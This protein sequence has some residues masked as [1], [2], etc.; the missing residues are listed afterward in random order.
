MPLEARYFDGRHATSRLV[1]LTIADDRVIV[2]GEGVARDEP[3]GSVSIS[4]RIGRTPR[5]VRFV[6]DAYCEVLDQDA[7]DGLLAA[8]GLA[9]GSLTRWEQNSR[10]VAALLVGLVLLAAVAYRYGLPLMAEA[11][12]RRLP[13]SALNAV[14]R[15]ALAVFDR[16][17][18]VPSQLSED[19]QRALT[20][21]FNRAT[22][23][24]TSIPMSLQFRS[25]PSL[26]ANAMALPNGIVILTDDLEKL[27]ASDDEILAVLAHEAGHV[28]ARHGL[29]NV[30]QSS[31]ISVFVTWYLGDIN[32]IV[33]AAPAALLEAK[34]SR[35]LERDADRY[36][37]TFLQANGLQT[38]LLADILQKLEASR[39][40]GGFSGATA[41][42]SSHPTTDERIR[43]L[44]EQP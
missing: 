14:S 8:A 27:A 15:Q 40:G 18:F 6:D 41:Y 36:A 23:P 32:A 22:H 11:S 9:Q 24:E 44:R 17:L 1:T 33:A 4:E 5:F 35:D 7:L 38:S 31:V 3:L 34:Y 29:R 43:V 28:Q 21:R 39:P 20:L 30:I 12:A 16:T 42:L 2:T 10:L 19:R 37:S 25:A 13:R 26:G